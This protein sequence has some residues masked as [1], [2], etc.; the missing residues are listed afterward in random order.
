MS[1]LLRLL[2]YCFDLRLVQSLLLRAQPLHAAN[3]IINIGL[4]ALTNLNPDREKSEAG[5]AT[6]NQIEVTSVPGPL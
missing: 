6:S 5:D 4:R 1:C 2:S 3:L